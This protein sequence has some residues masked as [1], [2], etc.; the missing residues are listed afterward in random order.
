MQKILELEFI[1]KEN[2]HII[3]K[4][5]KTSK[6]MTFFEKLR[7]GSAIQ[8]TDILQTALNVYTQR[9]ACFAESKSS[10]I[11]AFD[12]ANITY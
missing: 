7:D 6:L 12:M 11:E 1:S 8:F 4:Q 5:S 9:S 3:N 10:I 2:A